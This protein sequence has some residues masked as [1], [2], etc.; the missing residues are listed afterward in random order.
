MSQPPEGRGSAYSS[1]G[2]DYSALDA[3]KRSALS[4]ALAT[5]GLLASAQGRAVDESRGEPAFVFELAGQ[6]LAFVLEGLGTKSI[7]ARQ[8]EDELGPDGFA[9]VAYDTVAAIVNDLCCVGAVPLVVNA[10]F[11]TGSSEW[12]SRR[13]RHEALLRG[14]REGCVDA[15]AT[16]GG[17][18]SPSLPGLVAAQDIELAGCA[19]GLVPPGR[20]PILGEDLRPGDEIVFVD[21]S[22]LH[23][24]GASLARKVAGE[25]PER[26]ATPLPSGRSFGEALL[27]PSVMY[28]GLVRRLLGDDIDV[29]YLSH[30]TGHGLLKLMRP[31]RELGYEVTKLPLVP[32]VLAFLVERTGM[33]ASAAYSTFNMGCGYAVYCAAGS[34]ERVVALS[35][36]LGLG[37]HVAGTVTEGPRRVVLDELGV[38]FE[39]DDLDFT[40]R[41]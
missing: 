23:A 5:S 27:E 30:I 16:W 3:G 17:G 34:G 13:E 21:S 18:E 32:E 15:G 22:G 12:Y 6:S 8:L 11:A 35:S 9:H 24:N 26:Y 20:A 25:L 36:E 41:A 40:P 4:E 39:S 28:A 10:Y 7:I 38:V 33:T 19:V 1:A 29:H 37:A 31:R 2:V 14:W